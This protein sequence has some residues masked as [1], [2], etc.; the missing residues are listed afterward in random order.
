MVFVNAFTNLISYLENLWKH[1]LISFL[2]H[3]YEHKLQKL[4]TISSTICNLFLIL[5]FLY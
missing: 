2:M 1:K 3:F 5:E 4:H